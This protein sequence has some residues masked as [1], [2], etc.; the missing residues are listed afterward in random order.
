M[1]NLQI[2]C[3]K[4][5]SEVHAEQSADCPNPNLC[6]THIY[7]YIHTHTHTHTHFKQYTLWLTSYIALNQSMQNL[8]S[9]LLVDHENSLVQI[10]PRYS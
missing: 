5:R 10:S 6:I 3:A 1:N 9:I 4:V 2:G 7:I 8:E